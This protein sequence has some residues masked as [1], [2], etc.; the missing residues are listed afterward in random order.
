MIHIAVHVDL[1][2]NENITDFYVEAAIDG[3]HKGVFRSEAPTSWHR[4][5][6]PHHSNYN[7]DHAQSK[8]DFG[9][10][11]TYSNRFNSNN[12]STASIKKIRVD[13]SGILIPNGNGEQVT[14]SIVPNNVLAPN[15]SLSFVRRSKRFKMTNHLADHCTQEYWSENVTPGSR[16]MQFTKRWSYTKTDLKNKTASFRFVS[17]INW[18]F[19]SH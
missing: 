17:W 9:N 3:T 13:E 7:G 19:F 5:H 6:K 4:K 8:D 15:S 18:V 2:K 11:R 1:S 10:R 14:A 12:E 16:I